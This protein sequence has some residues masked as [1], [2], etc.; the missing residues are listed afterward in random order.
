MKK[1]II[2]IILS[3][4][5]P[6]LIIPFRSKAQKTM[7]LADFAHFSAIFGLISENPDLFGH[8]PLEEM[9]KNIIGII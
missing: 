8:L 4:F 2:L 9:K 3:D 6:E 5:L 1:N 7:I